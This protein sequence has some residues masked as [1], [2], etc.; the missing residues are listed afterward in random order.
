MGLQG[1]VAGLW[2]WSAAVQCLLGLS[3]NLRCW[4]GGEWEF[5]CSEVVGQC[6]QGVVK[7]G[8]FVWW[9]GQS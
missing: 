9:D 1:S 3:G 2:S 5:G 6:V 7:L 8:D 4:V